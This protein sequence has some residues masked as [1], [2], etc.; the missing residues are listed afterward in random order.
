MATLKYSDRPWLCPP[1]SGQNR[2]LYFEWKNA[3]VFVVESIYPEK[4]TSINLRIQADDLE[5]LRA[6][7]RLIE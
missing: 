3:E 7:C 5:R 4:I 6:V 1:A 2:V